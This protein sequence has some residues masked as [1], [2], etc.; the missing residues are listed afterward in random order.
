MTRLFRQAAVAAVFCALLAPAAQA[1]SIAIN[2]G[3]AVFDPPAGPGPRLF[4]NL[5]GEDFSV[6]LRW[7]ATMGPCITACTVGDV[8]SL[9][10][11]TLPVSPTEINAVTGPVENTAVGTWDGL[12]DL[13][14]A[15]QLRFAG[16]DVVLPPVPPDAELPFPVT[17]PSA[18]RSAEAFPASSCSAFATRGSSSRVTCLDRA[19][20]ARGSSEGP[21][22]RTFSTGSKTISNQYPNRRRCCCWGPDSQHGLAAATVV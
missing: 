1:E 2:A 3:T 8:V 10:S 4:A 16:P 5:S 11:I 7:D 14:F 12:S 13:A 21:T 6:S 15:G 9:F 22:G 20:C 18:S 17:S 19:L